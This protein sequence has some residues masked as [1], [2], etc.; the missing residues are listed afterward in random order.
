MTDANKSGAA[1]QAAAGN[2]EMIPVSVVQSIREELKEAK[3]IAREA[4]NQL[5]QIYQQNQTGG[6]PKKE[7]DPLDKAFEG[8]EEDDVL[9]AGD[10]KKLVKVLA[11]RSAP[12]PAG[13]DPQVIETLVA[14]QFPDYKEVVT[15]YLV[16]VLKESPELATAIRG[17][18]NPY[19][20]A[21]KIAKTNPKYATDQAEK[22]AAGDDKG[23]GNP[24]NKDPAKRVQENLNK[25]GSSHQHGAAAGGLG[26]AHEYETMSEDDL[27]KRIEEVLSKG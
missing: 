13:T 15:N 3:T 17:S 2:E 1:S 14:V 12:A 19:L 11:D 10:M 20:A 24:A 9:T 18:S 16:D 4:Q 23:D 5:F 27:E 22:K 21:Y 6:T 7:D 25:P 8:M 26:K